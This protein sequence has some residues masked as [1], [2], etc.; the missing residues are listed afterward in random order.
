VL[1]K[2]AN[3]LRTALL[4]YRVTGGIATFQEHG[5]ALELVI[6]VVWAAN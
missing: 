5:S 4:E 3:Q 6:A 2:V 1:I